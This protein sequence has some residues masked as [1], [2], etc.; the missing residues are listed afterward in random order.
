MKFRRRRDEELGINLTPLIDVVFLLLIFFMVSTS[1]TRATQLA[2]NLPEAE[3]VSAGGSGESMELV[4]QANGK[5]KLNGTVVSSDHAAL[6]EAMEV[7]LAN[8]G[9]QAL[10]IAADGDAP[11]RLVVSALDAA[12]ILGVEQ[13]TI[14]TQEPEQ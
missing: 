6:R 12:N 13:V 4:I 3:G 8:T 5:V 9:L 1:F 2:V 11:H 10:T 14:A 7:E